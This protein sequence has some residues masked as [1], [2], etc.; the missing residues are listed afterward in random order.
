MKK[1]SEL[2][3]YKYYIIELK[4][5]FDNKDEEKFTQ[6]FKQ[7]ES[8]FKTIRDEYYKKK[9][10]KYSSFFY[11]PLTEMRIS[12]ECLSLEIKHNIKLYQISNLYS[13]NSKKQILLERM[14][15]ILNYI[16]DNTRNSIMM[17]KE[18]Y[19]PLLSEQLMLDEIQNELDDLIKFYRIAKREDYTEGITYVTNRIKELNYTSIEDLTNKID[20]KSLNQS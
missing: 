15:K 5:A 7:I 17:S 2:S 9:I 3:N 18:V 1:I 6:I 19:Y 4:N 11:N 10:S 13:L 14:L 12:S 8:D 16:R 20:T